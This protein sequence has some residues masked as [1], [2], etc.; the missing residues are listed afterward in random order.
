MTSYKEISYRRI[1][2]AADTN[3]SKCNKRLYKNQSAYIRDEATGV[4]VIIGR[5]I[6]YDCYITEIKK[7]NTTVEKYYVP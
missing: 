4:F 3:C 5:P 6:C 1:Y 2:L 7:V